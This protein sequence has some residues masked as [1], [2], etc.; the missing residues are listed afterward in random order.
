MDDGRRLPTPPGAAPRRRARR[1]FPSSE[2]GNPQPP[3][4]WVLQFT[5]AHPTVPVPAI[6]TPPSP[7]PWAPTQA[8]SASVTISA[9]RNGCRRFAPRPDS[10]ARW[11]QPGRDEPP[12]AQ[13]W[14]GQVGTSETLDCSIRNRCKTQIEPKTQVRQAGYSVTPSVCPENALTNGHS[15]G[16]RRRPRPEAIHSYQPRDASR[17]SSGAL[18]LCKN[19]LG[20]IWVDSGA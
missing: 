18:P 17:H 14:F 19:Q 4:R 1:R 5:L 12:L 7:S 13:D 8:A 3:T 9:L 20:L 11:R 16:F 15:T 10:R 2:I 6:I